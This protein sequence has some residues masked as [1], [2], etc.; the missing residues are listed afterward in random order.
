MLKLFLIIIIIFITTPISAQV[1]NG[2]FNCHSSLKNLAKNFDS[3]ELSPEEFEIK[4]IQVQKEC[5][6]CIKKYKV[7]DFRAKASNNDSVVLSSFEKKVVVINFWAAN[8]PPC[9]V[10]IPILNKL[11]TYYKDKNI[12]FISLT[13]NKV[14][15]KMKKYISNFT[16]IENAITIFDSYGVIGYPQ[17]LV[18]KKNHFLQHIF[19][20][21]DTN[22]INGFENEIKR[23]IETALSE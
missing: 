8:C 17:T 2:Y 19:M 3:S 10:E 11:S 21:I 12:I 13:M 20:G 14:S 15:E 9:L 4:Y 23:E 16:I 7:P 6:V 18:L 5:E 22:N 1:D